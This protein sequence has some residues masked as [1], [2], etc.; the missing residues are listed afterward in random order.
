MASVV[1]RPP[2][3]VPAESGEDPTLDA[4]T[5]ITPDPFLA[6]VAR[7]PSR[8]ALPTSDP[9]LRAGEE[10]GH[11]V[12]LSEL[13]RGGMGVVY[14][15]QDR[16][17]GRTVALKVLPLSDDEGRKK[18]FLRE[19]RA[20]AALTH[21]GIAIIYEIGEVA[22][23]VFIAMELVRGR[24]LR[25][26]F[27]EGPIAVAEAQRIAVE[28]ARALARAH[29]RGVVH[30]DLKPENVML[31]EDGAVKLLDFGLAKEITSDDP[32]L[33]T[34]TTATEHGRILGTPTY[35]SPEQSKGRPVDAR[36]DVFSF[37]V[38]LYEML[39]GRRPF[40]GATVVELFIALDRDEPVPPSKANPRVPAS[41]E[42]VVLRCLRKDP[43]ARYADASA[44]LRDLGPASATAARPPRR[45]GA[46]VAGLAAVTVAAL[47]V[48]L[49]PRSAPPAPKVVPTA[50]TDLPSP[51]S[52]HPEAVAAYRAG[53]KSYREGTGIDSWERAVEIDPDLAAAHAQLS[54]EVMGHA[55]EVAR[56]HFRKANELR[57]KLTPRDLAM[58]D[59]MEPLVQRQPADWAESNR[60]LTEAV[61][62]FPGDAELWQLLG[63]GRANYDD[64]EA[65]VT[66]TK[67]AIE[68]DPAFAHA[69]AS[70]AMD[71]LYLG[72]FDEAERV[73]D[74]CL[75][76]SPASVA[77]LRQ[78][79]KLR[80][81][82]GQCEAMEG[83]ARRMIAAGA[84][85]YASYLTLAQ[86][87]AAR[88]APVTSVREAL[89]QAEHGLGDLTA[90]T[91]TAIA[92]RQKK[93]VLD[94]TVA[95]LEGDFESVLKLVAEYAP[96]IEHSRQ[97]SD[98]AGFTRAA[99]E[100]YLE[101]GRD[102]DAG[103]IA[104]DFLDRR[105]AWEPAPGAEDVAM[106][107]DA[108]PYLLVTAL[109]AGV[110][111]RADFEARRDAWRRAWTAKVTPVTRR[112]LWLHG[113]AAMVDTAEDARA[114]VAALPAYEPLPPF[115]PE[116][117]VDVAVA[118]T[119]L[120]AG[121]VDDAIAWAERAAGSCEILR[122]PIEH[123][124]A[125]LLLGEAR[126][127]KG[128][129]PGACSAL[130]QVLARWGQAKPRSVTAERARER[131]RALGCGG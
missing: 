14:A 46:I 73:A 72:R 66:D 20:A 21:P 95:E 37:G 60:R 85:A 43:A 83:V 1:V 8:T 105:D 17:L 106:G 100:L 111:T 18:R 28:I 58:L 6:E 80:S 25:A 107:S 122:F 89:R 47:A 11:F 26:R 23:R 59:A 67:R 93:I 103:K 99:A 12:I 84:P 3:E 87:L 36:S 7:I 128:D 121:R 50:I 113:Y 102:A 119:F 33:G 32:G 109:R 53:L 82:R 65:A 54:T 62:R 19:A 114:A 108:T 39:T 94:S 92:R 49:G 52:S 63:L 126:A 97:Q 118:R 41:L 64:F 98:H 27:E 116:S 4:S 115:R 86:A 130:G 57:E 35:M 112:F 75:A 76:A 123:M 2:D 104:L 129:K 51:P 125:L 77:C 79:A 10:L 70:L 40:T 81:T 124:H 117:R 90:S 110:I 69:Y 71:L 45:L 29:E 55:M 34:A 22:G 48:A 56:E 68:L 127:Q 30:R 91:P 61:K 31:A 78:S 24:N 38:M 88:G 74:Q 42:R 5:S 96:T 120:L 9:P 16:N 131:Q 44:L 13:G 101:M 15:A